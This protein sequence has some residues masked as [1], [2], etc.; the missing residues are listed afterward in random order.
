M[1]QVTNRFQCIQYLKKLPEDFATVKVDVESLKDNSLRKLC[2]D[3]EKTLHVEQA[4][5]NYSRDDYTEYLKK[6][7]DD[8]QMDTKDIEKSLIVLGNKNGMLSGRIFNQANFQ[9][10]LIDVRQ[11]DDDYPIFI[12]S[13]ASRFLETGKT[14][15]Q[16]KREREQTFSHDPE[17]KQIRVETISD[18]QLALAEQEIEYK[19]ELDNWQ[20]KYYSSQ[21]NSEKLIEVAN[22]NE[23]ALLNQVNELRQI[24]AVAHQNQE[25]LTN[26]V[27][28]L[29]SKVQ[30]LEVTRMD[31]DINQTDEEDVVNNEINELRQVNEDLR[32]KIDEI[33]NQP[34]QNPARIMGFFSNMFD[35]LDSTDI[36]EQTAAMEAEE[37]KK[38]QVDPKVEKLSLNQMGISTWNPDTTSFLDY[39]ISLR[40]IFNH[41]NITQPRA[42]HLLFSSLPSKY[43]YVRNAVRSY[44]GFEYNRKNYWEVENIVIEMVVGG[45]DKI[46]SEFMNLQKKKNENFIQY[47][48]KVV[49]FY[50]FTQ[51]NTTYQGQ[52]A[53]E[54]DPIAFKLIKD[55]MVKAIPN[56]LVP[57]FK[58]RIEGKTKLP[59][60]FK[61]VLELRE[62]FPE[63]ESFEPDYNGTNLNVLKQQKKPD[64]TKNVKC[65][66]CG[67]KGHIKKDCYKRESKT[68]KSGISRK[69]KKYQK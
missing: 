1:M 33:S 30:Q 14:S 26:Q 57:E 51:S 50:L 31:E 21:E 6:L 58:R 32:S 49:D 5:L 17:P 62:Q 36:A 38:N 8:E 13:S 25:D 45:K 4:A 37:K 29:Q 46:F 18:L 56:Q 11:F 7:L 39:I 59:E 52:K 42:I 63:T 48:Q 54:S 67:K 19:K 43:S 69:D 60:M 22:Q 3:L 53:I 65:F 20:T 64:W 23:Q 28:V 44:P 68:K 16:V 10:Q 15:E 34:E 35:E 47:Y 27:N 9:K 2:R 55:K 24:N 66:H 12:D 41:Y 61:A 40:S